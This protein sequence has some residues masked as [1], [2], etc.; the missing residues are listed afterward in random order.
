MVLLD[1]PP[2]ILRQGEERRIWYAIEP[3]ASEVRYIRDDGVAWSDPTLLG[4]EGE[5]DEPSSTFDF[6]NRRTDP[7]EDRIGRL[8]PE[9]VA[10]GPTAREVGLSPSFE[11]ELKRI[12]K[13]HRATLVRPMETWSL[14][15]IEAEYLRLRDQSNSGNEKQAVELRLTQLKHQAE[16]SRSARSLREL[17]ENSRLRDK[18]FQRIRERLGTIASGDEAPYDAEGLL[19][20]SSTMLD[21]HKALILINDAG[22]TDAYVVMPPG[23]RIDQYVAT[24][25]GIRGDSRYDARLKARVINVAEIDRL[26]TAP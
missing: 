16:T 10:V 7:S 5:K 4:T 21:G 26:D 20:T 3:P 17:I 9:F 2:L 18:E 24:R 22:K 25:V 19:Q 13:A 11:A 1:R 14:A 8:D 15:P 6:V 12:E 23:L